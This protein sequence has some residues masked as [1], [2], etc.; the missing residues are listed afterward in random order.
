[1]AVAKIK[2]PSL[3]HNKELAVLFSRMADCYRYLGQDERFRAIAYDT[4]SKT[5]N[6]MQEPVDALADDVKKLDELKGV[7]ESI[8]AKI[9]EYL[10][11]GRVKTFEQLKKK[12]PFHLLELMDI[13]GFGPATVHL[14]HDKLGIESREELVRAL[15]EGKLAGIRGI[16]EKKIENMR[17]VLKL[18]AAKSRLPLAEAEKIGRRILAEVQQIPGVHQ[19]VLAG[20]LRRKKETIGDI[21][22]L[23]TAEGRQW[24]K[25]VTRFTRL[26]QVQKVLAAGSTRASVQLAPRGVQV[27]IRI[28]HEDEFG[29]ALMYFTGSKEHNILIR[30]LARRKGWKIN[31]YGLFEEATGRRLA[32]RTEEE[33]YS[34][35]GVSFIPP[36]KRLG[37]DEISLAMRE[38]V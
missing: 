38:E 13:E 31:E 5:L 12:V 26:P 37:K 34:R 22:I 8:A 25:I 21:D 16:G 19:A 18:E 2:A 27:D 32:G 28:V 3:R 29:A 24:K 23:V 36:E 10:E 35:L 4:A 33:I 14:L 7:G 9:V 17:R 11:T 20:S 30:T 15:E 6:N 1:M